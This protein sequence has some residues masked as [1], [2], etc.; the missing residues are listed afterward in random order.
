MDVIRHEA[1][2]PDLKIVTTGVEDKQFQV[3][4]VV[5]RFREDC[6]TVI[7]PLGDVVGAACGYGA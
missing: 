1:V 2:S 7:A 5:L 4:G 3:V 6:L